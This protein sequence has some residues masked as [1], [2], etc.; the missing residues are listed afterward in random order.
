LPRG[1]LTSGG[2]IVAWFASGFPE[3]AGHDQLSHTAGRLTRID[4]HRA[5]IATTRATWMC[6]TDG[7]TASMTATI[8]VDR[9]TN[10]I[11]MLACLS[12]PSPVLRAQVVKSLRSLR[13]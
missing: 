13:S 7:G 10:N 12:H 11:T 3:P 6:K 1:R 8:A 4:G 5:K 9:S 2:L